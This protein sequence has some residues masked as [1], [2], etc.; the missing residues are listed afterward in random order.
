MFLLGYLAIEYDIA[1]PFSDKYENIVCIFT[2]R[3]ETMN[4]Y[5]RCGLQGINYHVVKRYIN[6]FLFLFLITACLK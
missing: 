1:L 2:T 5:N 6:V 4:I 3:T